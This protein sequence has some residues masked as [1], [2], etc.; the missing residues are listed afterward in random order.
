[1]PPS[2]ELM[3]P[4]KLKKEMKFVALVSG[5]K[6]SIYSI[7]E[8]IRNNHELVA[9]VHLGAPAVIT[10]ES[11]MYQTAA[12]E[13]LATLVEQC[14]GV[15]LLLYQRRGRS[16]NTSLVYEQEDEDDE[17][18]DLYQ[19]LVLA[20][21]SF[22]E[23]Q[24]V[25]SGAILSTYQR[26]R[27]EN[28]CCRLQ[29]T[30]LSYLWRMDSQHALLQRM[31]NDGIE[32]ILVK[33]ACPPGL[34][35][36]KERLHE[37]YQFH[38]C[39]E[40][41][42]YESLVVDCPIYKK[43]LVLDDTEIVETDDGVGVLLIHSCHAEE[44]ETS[45][46]SIQ[47]KTSNEIMVSNDS[48]IQ[49]ELETRTPMPA[50]KLLYLPH[51]RQMPGGLLHVSEITSPVTAYSHDI[52]VSEADLAVEEFKAV[53]HLLMAILTRFGATPQDVLIVHLYLSEIS[54]FQLINSHYR[55]FFGTLLP[56]SRSCVA[57]G[58]KKF[59]GGRRVLMDC[60][61]QIG[62]GQYM[63]NKDEDPYAK[64]ALLTTTS[65]LRQV[66]HVQ[67]ISY[68][69][70]VCVGPY[71][72]VNTLR[73][74]LH[75]LAGQIGLV[76]AT[77][78]LQST[79][80]GQLDQCWTNVARVLDGLDGGS[81]QNMLSCLVYVSD[82]VYEKGNAWTTVESICRQKILINGNVVR[83]LVDSTA[84]LDTLYGGYEDEGTWREMTQDTAETSDT[85]LGI[86]LLFVSIPEMPMGALAE[87]ETICST[88]KAATCLEMKSF[89]HS[90]SD[91]WSPLESGS[92]TDW[93]T[94]HDFALAQPSLTRDITVNASTRS[95]GYG[96][97]AMTIV[98][99][100]LHECA[101][102]D[103]V[104]TNLDVEN[105][106]DVMIGAVFQKDFVDSSGLSV[107]EIIHIRLYY[108]GAE[109]FE[110]SEEDTVCVIDD[111]MRLRTALTT[112]LVSRFA[113]SG[114]SPSV[115]IPATTVVPVQA[116]KVVPPSSSVA[117]EGTTIMAMQVLLADPV[118]LETELWI[119]H[120][121]D[122]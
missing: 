4:S 18:E 92:T 54:H 78:K 24:A 47:P 97:A 94:G 9:C 3:P 76:P 96:C 99:A 45:D 33:T 105:L 6:D 50:P 22:P 75:F 53:L 67:S 59:P 82:Q 112:V 108:I 34:I 37:K 16:S 15:P 103:Q 109:L 20:K 40:G 107:I 80:T 38:L 29:L 90:Q 91:I 120:C 32:A 84:P 122:E 49:Q 102:H 119:H 63:R 7:V 11:F 5:G 46:T 13:V 31:L 48:P 89:T 14:L 81:L 60:M 74:G 51:V 73:S 61:I 113:A 23:I 71:S 111:G 115:T 86:P 114:Q 104:A 93:D 39:G 68:W 66:L 21:Q 100:S 69:A 36:S 12:S 25:S 41:G 26:V 1:M 65:S 83:G 101:A 77:M 121:R 72:Q 27:I 87:V 42:E 116:M 44:K 43:R 35:P 95:L 30:S 117:I 98:S 52:T 64:A 118:H 8:C 58:N 57:V 17:V 110:I 106:L 28:V 79:W 10:E 55:D 88:Q 85:E 56:P 62:S 19:A 2:A 70:P